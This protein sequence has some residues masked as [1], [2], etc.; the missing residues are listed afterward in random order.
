[1]GNAGKGTQIAK[2][3]DLLLVNG[4]NALTTREPGGTSG[5]E[6]IRQLIFELKRSNL[7]TPEEQMVLFFAS[8]KL[9]ITEVI[10]PALSEGKVV[11]GDRF[12]TSTAAYQGFAE[13]GDMQKIISLV[14]VGLGG[15]K[16]DATILLDISPETALARLKKGGDG[17]DP[18]DREKEDYFERVIA[19]Y[20]EMARTCWGG[21]NWYLVNGEQSVEKV[22]DSV[23]EVLE[24]ILGQKL[25]RTG[26]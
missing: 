23:A 4:C 6:E 19:G 22:S 21:L 10:E 20:R 26:S 24:D 18:F 16:P 17:N 14:D 2:T 11:L 12:Y 1:M 13:G 15:F 5:G 3:Y 8:R 9:L 25:T 7:I